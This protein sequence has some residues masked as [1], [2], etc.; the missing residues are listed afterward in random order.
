MIRTLHADVFNE[1]A[2]HPEVRPWLGGT[3]ELD[4][5][6]TIANPENFA[7]LTDEEMGGYIYHKLQPGLYAVH[8]LSLPEGRG[9]Q[10][11]GARSQSLR[12]MFI[13]SDAVEIVTMVPDGNLGALTWAKHAG[14]RETFRRESAFDLMG[15]M[16]GVSY[17]SLTY[18]DWVIHDAANRR[19]GAI[20]HQAIHQVVEDDHGDDPVH[21]ALVGATM[22]G[23][24]NGNIEKAIT[25]YNR[26]AV[27]AGYQ[28]IKVLTTRPLVLDI[29][30]AIIEYSAD[31]LFILHVRQRPKGSV[32]D[33]L[34]PAECP[35]P[36]LQPVQA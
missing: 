30:S 10:M 9:R 7:F 24:L 32:E 33:V 4:L 25:L 34:E 23:C 11:L 5:T 22:E 35:S 17:Q 8:T 15:E 27:H 1:I 19:E 29:S 21:N 6:E 28:P 31:G 16:V 3:H 13:K 12:E 20:F 14:F 36:P 18:Q 2:N 26:Y